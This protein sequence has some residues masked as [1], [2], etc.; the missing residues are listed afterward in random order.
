M[1]RVTNP[2]FPLYL[3]QLQ[4]TFDDAVRES[5]EVFDMSEEEAVQ[6]AIEEFHLQVRPQTVTEEHSFFTLIFSN[7]RCP[8]TPKVL[9][10]P[11]T[12]RGSVWNHLCVWGEP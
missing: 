10:P 2:F 4:D 5:M 8:L 6:S 7:S 12:G 3:S 11:V 1:C 9:S